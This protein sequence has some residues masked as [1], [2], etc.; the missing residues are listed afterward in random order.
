[1]G[2]AV[3]F[4][5]ISHLPIADHRVSSAFT[6]RRMSEKEQTCWC[7]GQEWLEKVLSTQPGH[8]IL[9]KAKAWQCMRMSPVIE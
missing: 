8:K 2:T 5:W 7:L 4:Q 9:S 6:Y 3:G 1:M